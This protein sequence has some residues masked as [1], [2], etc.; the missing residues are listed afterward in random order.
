MTIA[1]SRDADYLALDLERD[2]SVKAWVAPDEG[3]KCPVSG[4]LR[5]HDE[6]GSV[7]AEGAAVASGLDCG[8]V[9]PA[10]AEGVRDLPTGRHFVSFTHDGSDFDLAITYVLRIVLLPTPAEGEPCSESA[11]LLPCA[12]GLACGVDDSIC[13]TAACGDGV[14]TVEVG[15]ECDDGATEP[16]DG[17]APDCRWE[18]F[19]ELEPNDS[20]A[21]AERPGEARC[22]WAGAL[23]DSSD[24]DWY[25]VRSEAPFVAHARLTE[26]EGSCTEVLSPVVLTLLDGT[27][28]FVELAGESEDDA[29]CPLIA[30]RSRTSRDAA[31]LLPAG[32]YFLRVSSVPGWFEGDPLPYTLSWRGGTCRG[33]G[34]PL[35]YKGGAF[36]D[37]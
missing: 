32:T 37:L 1:R 33:V 15:E 14:T 31:S 18:V 9:D 16:G 11:G 26:A 34:E 4:T 24:R 19:S 36:G 30:P 12:R 28:R 22:R 10:A 29:P 8:L 13:R 20:A 2:A 23:K 27:G 5:L 21:T 6:E 17:C 25:E 7:L 35:P 3:G